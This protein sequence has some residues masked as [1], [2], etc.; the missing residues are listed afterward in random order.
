MLSESF[1][2]KLTDIFFYSFLI[3][4]PLVAFCLF[5]WKLDNT[6]LQA[7]GNV[8][9]SICILFCTLVFSLGLYA[10]AFLQIS[11]YIQ[12]KNKIS[13]SGRK[14]F[15]EF[16]FWAMAGGTIPILLLFMITSIF[17]FPPYN[18]P[19]FTKFFYW[20]CTVVVII[21]VLYM[22]TTIVDLSSPRS[23]KQYNQKKKITRLTK[24]FLGRKK[25][26]Y[27][28]SKWLIIKEIIK[29]ILPHS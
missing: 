5:Y 18:V 19:L 24:E 26:K 2:D 15:L 1:K 25:P 21:L 29:T 9:I 3:A 20:F 17:D 16:L 6:I 13:K 11:T 27:P 12:E 7:I 28:T 14:R 22:V 23:F 8:S 10:L 4:I